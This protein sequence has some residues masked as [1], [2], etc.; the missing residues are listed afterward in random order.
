M[1]SPQSPSKMSAPIELA[2]VRRLFAQPHKIAGADFLRREIATRM[3]E[4]LGLVRIA[5]QR[6]LD[7]GCGA[8]ADLAPLQK[9]YPA[10]QIL[11][12][13]AAPAMALAAKAPGARS[14]LSR[15][16][17]AKA[18]IDLLAGDFGDLPADKAGLAAAAIACAASSPS[19]WAAG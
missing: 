7:A 18:G 10:A 14:L 16:L 4:R 8:G 6:V 13:D 11:G 17:P 3:H 19:T 2:R 12:I 5:P 15:L 1:V 9:D